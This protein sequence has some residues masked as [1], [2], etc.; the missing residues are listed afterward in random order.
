MVVR[1]SQA[2][3]VD[4]AQH[5]L[6]VSIAC[7]SERQPELPC[8]DVIA[9]I[10]SGCSSVIRSRH[11]HLLTPNAFR[12]SVQLAKRMCIARKASKC[13]RFLK[14]NATRPPSRHSQT[15]SEPSQPSDS[16]SEANWFAD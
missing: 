15:Q 2:F 10:V 12:N 7:L 3:L 11:R 5:G 9:S 1:D 8:R 14:E 13:L 4:D 16:A 6:G